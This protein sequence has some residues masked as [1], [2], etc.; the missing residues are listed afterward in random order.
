MRHSPAPVA[1]LEEQRPSKP[2]VAG[3]NPAGCAYFLL[4]VVHDVCSFNGAV[5]LVVIAGIVFRILRMRA[6]L[7]LLIGCLVS[8][9]VLHATALEQ[10]VILQAPLSTLVRL[11][12]PVINAPRALAATV[13]V[14]PD[15]PSD[16]GVGA[17]VVDQHGQ[18]FQTIRPGTLA[19]GSHEL[20][21]SLGEQDRLLAAN[22]FQAW[23]PAA[24]A[25]T[26]GA[27]LF[28]YSASN[29]RAQLIIRQAQREP[30]APEPT[31]PPLP[32]LNQL[33]HPTTIKTGERWELSLLPHPFPQNPFD[34]REFSLSAEITLP[35]GTI[36]R[37][38]GFFI[39]PMELLDRGDRA[40]STPAQAG[41]FALRFRPQQMGPHQIAITAQWGHENAAQIRQY[42][43]SFI[44][45][46]EAWDDYVR[47]D[48]S[49]PRF[50]S[51]HGKWY[52]PVGPNV[53]SVNDVRGSNRLRT[54]LTPDRGLFAYDAYLRRLAAHQVNAVEVWMSSWNLALEWNAAW[55]G[56][57]GVGRYNM[58]NAD[59]LD[60]LLD[61]AWSLGIRINLVLNNHGQASSAF[62]PEWDNN[63]Y[64][65]TLGGPLKEAVE[66]FS[67]PAALE[68]QARLR[69]YIVAR[70][71]DH[72]AIIGWKLWSEVNLTAGRG[73]VLRQ[74]HEQA[75]AAWKALDY[76]QHP[77]TTHWCGDYKLVDREIAAQPGID[78]ICIDAYHD[79]DH[80][81]ADLL[82]RS[83]MDPTPR[84]GLAQ[85]GKPVLTTEFGGNW[86]ACPKPQLLAE[87]LSGP[88]AALVSGHAGCPMLWWFE[89]LDQGN[90]FSP[91]PAIQRFIAGEDIRGSDARSIVLNATSAH[92]SL[93][94]R[95]WSRPGRLLGYVLDHEWGKNGTSA[96]QHSAVNIQIGSNINPG[97]I[98]VAWWDANHGTIIRTDTI[99]HAGGPL[100]ITPPAFTQHIA[101]KLARE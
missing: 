70:Y 59:K 9:S 18:W 99:T 10:S 21:F 27:G 3:S 41:R 76:Y 33:Q 57:H 54:I 63:P 38:P 35:D 53:R 36:A 48:K 68:G 44:A 45:S 67:A 8:G 50:F 65:Q 73:T 97:K 42:T 71:A 88:W 39:Q 64:N 6:F 2:S 14:P 80:L 101:Y 66:I 47:V 49:D 20:R 1:Q 23:T 60:R 74:W 86:D 46:G 96:I 98:I 61:L 81:L 22:N 93:W 85:F 91:Y 56:F 28:F 62:D 12:Q 24:A 30:T 82:W 40:Y 78:Y 69:R 43:T 5:F 79:N 4:G 19:P 90:Y 15:A 11:S 13:V 25:I 32:S 31:S 94:H 55:P 52:W 16:L 17:F 95:A 26:T 58:K 7:L 84:R 72:P 37:V 29:S 83:T 100:I 87:H 34:D 51:V 89:W 75:S 92:G 77:V